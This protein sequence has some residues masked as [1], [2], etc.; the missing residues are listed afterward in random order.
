MTA[1]TASRATRFERT[2]LAAAAGLD[3]FVEARLERRRD[4]ASP[5]VA[6]ARAAE[7]RADALA[8]GAT[9]ILPR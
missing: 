9:G 5:T 3:H 8:L 1:L 6:P 4:A 2:L 7:A